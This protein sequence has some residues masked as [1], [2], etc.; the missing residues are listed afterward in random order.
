MHDLKLREASD[1]SDE[2]VWYGR[3]FSESVPTTYNFV[4]PPLVVGMLK[5]CYKAFA[6]ELY[7]SRESEA[8]STKTSANLP[9]SFPKTSAKLNH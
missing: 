1:E 4:K 7:H 2:S 9:S 6:C 8:I 3:R 5:V